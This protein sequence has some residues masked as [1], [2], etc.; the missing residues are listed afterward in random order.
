MPFDV[1]FKL[2]NGEVPE[3]VGTGTAP[4]EQDWWII[5]NG[6]AG[7]AYLEVPSTWYLVDGNAVTNLQYRYQTLT[8]TADSTVLNDPTGSWSAWA[9]TPSDTGR[10]Q[11]SGLPTT[12]CAVQL[13]TERDSEYSVP[14]TF[15]RVGTYFYDFDDTITT[16]AGCIEYPIPSTVI[17]GTDNV[18]GEGGQRVPSDTT[19]ITAG[20][21]SGHFEIVTG[22][23]GYKYL[24]P[25]STG[26]GA[27]SAT[28]TYSLTLNDSG[29]TVVSVRIDANT[30]AV[31]APEW[32][33][34]SDSVSEYAAY[35]TRTSD[36]SGKTLLLRYGFYAPQETTN[37]TLRNHLGLNGLSSTFTMKAADTAAKPM[38]ARLN[39]TASGGA[40]DRDVHFN[41]IDFFLPQFYY[42]EEPSFGNQSQLEILD[43]A[44]DSNGSDFEISECNFRSD[45]IESRYGMQIR[46][47]GV[48]RVEVVGLDFNHNDGLNI[49]D[50]V[51]M[52][53]YY[54]QWYAG[55]SG[56]VSGNLVTHIAADYLNPQPS[57]Q[58]THDGALVYKNNRHR[59]HCG[60]QSNVHADAFHIW[61]S[62][63]ADGFRVEGNI[64]ITGYEARACP[65]QVSAFYS[66]QPVTVTASQS[67]TSS[68]I[69]PRSSGT[70]GKYFVCTTDNGDITLTIP[71][72]S[73]LSDNDGF[74]VLNFG[75]SGNSTIITDGAG[76]TETL[77]GDMENVFFIVTGGVWTINFADKTLQ[78]LYNN[79]GTQNWTD[80]AWRYNIISGNSALSGVFLNN[81]GTASRFFCHNNTFLSNILTV[82]DDVTGDGV[83]DERDGLPAT[84]HL[85]R[86]QTS[87]AYEFKNISAEDASSDTN[88]NQPYVYDSYYTG[89][90]TTDTTAARDVVFAGDSGNN[91]Y[92]PC[93]TFAQAIEQARAKASSSLDTD[94]IGAVGPL[95]TTTGFWNFSTGAFNGYPTLTA[96]YAVPYDGGVL[97]LND[98][99]EIFFNYPVQITDS[100]GIVL[101]NTTDTVAVAK[102]ATMVG[103]KLIITPD[104]ALTNGKEYEVTISATALD[105]W[106]DA[107][108]SYGG[109]TSGQLNFTASNNAY[110][111]L[112][113]GYDGG[114]ADLWGDFDGQDKAITI[115]Q[116]YDTNWAKG[117]AAAHL[118]TGDATWSIE[119]SKGA[120]FATTLLLTG[121]ADA[122]IHSLDINSSGT[123]VDSPTGSEGTD[124]GVE[125]LSTHWKLWISKAGSGVTRY[126]WEVNTG[127]DSVTIRRPMLIDA[128]DGDAEWTSPIGTL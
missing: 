62:G 16:W 3:I 54:A 113:I 11:L 108:V 29:T 122:G 71:L 55:C 51:F 49:H 77:S 1:N 80:T 14:S 89:D 90:V 64:W 43:V 78:G 25:T 112:L 45:Y 83:I 35:F 118:P 21:A 111:N 41:Y 12:P 102:T 88:T 97:G 126:Y 63:D 37:N 110:P 68:D 124:Y 107:A 48:D 23:D 56:T 26:V 87:G 69:G 17:W 74:G 125:D 109:L 116:R 24:Q 2:T 100:A 15:K 91:D 50:N 20:D 95:N 114:G 31:R 40:G 84:S 81:S 79:N 123:I 66:N 119:V 72:A 86:V 61:S 121:G 47:N 59:E 65:G 120:A 70:D 6:V 18:A 44:L 8:S 128:Q 36:V 94:I 33:I 60:D 34:S 82:G 76:Y 75:T 28:D 38:V 115:N 103:R 46:G 9:D 58:G 99:I 67:V 57:T 96:D 22:T 105:A 101:T 13:R 19:A 117:K 106:D 52:Y 42:Y 73:T 27:W 85:V 53:M 5:P 32:T 104:A 30:A 92:R 7:G 10:M 4:R 93:E 98:P 39:I 127:S